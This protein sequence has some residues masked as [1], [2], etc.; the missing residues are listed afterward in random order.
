MTSAT[1]QTRSGE[2]LRVLGAHPL[3]VSKE[4]PSPQSHTSSSCPELRRAGYLGGGRVDGHP[5]GR[6]RLVDSGKEWAERLRAWVL[7]GEALRKGLQPPSIG[8]CPSQ[9]GQW[10]LRT[11]KGVRCCL[12]SLLCGGNKG[13][14]PQSLVCGVPLSSSSPSPKAQPGPGPNHQD[15]PQWQWEAGGLGLRVAG[16]QVTG[17]GGS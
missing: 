16:Q 5:G 15:N 1:A 10:E 3:C 17:M 13:T 2:T 14:Y 4:L 6:G 12:R 7:P 9:G 11:A 8:T